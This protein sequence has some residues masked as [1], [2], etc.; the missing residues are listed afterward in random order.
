LAKIISTKPGTLIDE[1]WEAIIGN[2][3]QI[4]LLYID[5]ITRIEAKNLYPES[6]RFLLSAI[7]NLSPVNFALLNIAS[8]IDENFTNFSYFNLIILNI[9]YQFSSKNLN[10]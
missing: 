1:G 7:Y 5:F 3:S 4:S 9:F 10:I 2:L 6:S 8:V